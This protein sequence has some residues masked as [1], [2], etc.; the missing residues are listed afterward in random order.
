MKKQMQQDSEIIRE[1]TSYLEFK[2]RTNMKLQLIW[3]VLHGR[4]V[5]YGLTFIGGIELRDA[6]DDAIITGCTFIDGG[7]KGLPGRISYG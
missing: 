3:N 1:L 2:N 6:Q 4:Q 5:C 7:I